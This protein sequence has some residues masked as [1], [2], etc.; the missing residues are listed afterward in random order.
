MEW[1]KLKWVG[2]E[3]QKKLTV[4]CGFWSHRIQLLPRSCVVGVATRTRKLGRVGN[5]VKFIGTHNFAVCISSRS[6]RSEIIQFR[7]I[8]FLFI[9]TLS[10]FLESGRDCVHIRRWSR[11]PLFA[12]KQFR[13]VVAK[14]C[15]GTLLIR[16]LLYNASM[17]SIGDILVDIWHVGNVKSL[18]LWKGKLLLSEWGVCLVSADFETFW[19]YNWHINK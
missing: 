17:S 3:E 15:L 14:S 12:V 9:L 1:T 16:F 6:E 2:G 5:V 8:F 13:S 19:N 18:R 11:Q 4:N 7:L 10:H